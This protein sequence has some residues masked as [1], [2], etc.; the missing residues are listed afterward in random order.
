MFVQEIVKISVHRPY[1]KPETA[2]PIYYKQ[3]KFQTSA[4]FGYFIFRIPN[5]EIQYSIAAFN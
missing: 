1:S 4:E 2:T 3:N 5:N